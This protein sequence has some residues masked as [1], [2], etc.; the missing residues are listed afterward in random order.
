MGPWRQESARDRS[1]SLPA[2]PQHEAPGSCSHQ[3]NP[4]PCKWLR[5]PCISLLSHFCLLMDER[6]EF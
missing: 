3:G 5:E 1:S 2:G 4:S 6:T